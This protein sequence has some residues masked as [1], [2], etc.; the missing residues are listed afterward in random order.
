M[1][2]P[3]SNRKSQGRKK[4]PISDKG[5]GSV[6][7]LLMKIEED[8]KEIRELMKKKEEIRELMKK[9]R[10][11]LDDDEKERQT[12][13]DQELEKNPFW[14]MTVDIN[15]LNEEELANYMQAVKK[16]QHNINARIDELGKIDQSSSSGDGVKGVPGG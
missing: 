2:T 13:I 5:S 9:E 6:P 4:S 11:S 10:E 8:E 1:S 12:L 16:L 7:D 3:M 15:N 14:W